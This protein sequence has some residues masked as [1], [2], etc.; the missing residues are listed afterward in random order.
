MKI[1]IHD[2]ENDCDIEL[3]VISLVNGIVIGIDE[4][5]T[6]EE[7]LDN[8]EKIERMK[9]E[10]S[11]EHERKK[12]RKNPEDN[13]G[14]AVATLDTSEIERGVDFEN[15]FGSIWHTIESRKIGYEEFFS[16]VELLASYCEYYNYTLLNLIRLFIEHKPE[17]MTLD[18]IK[19]YIKPTVAE[20]QKKKA[21]FENE[22]EGSQYRRIFAHM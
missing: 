16:D 10:S 8:Y 6:E 22:V 17:I 1:D 19:K 13:L 11:N 4:S 2:Y 7:E 14:N 20:M 9:R 15:I 3:T 18:F 21:D 12:G 5:L